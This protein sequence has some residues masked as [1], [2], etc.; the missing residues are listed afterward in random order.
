MHLL[1]MNRRQK[2]QF[3]LSIDMFFKN[4]GYQ[5]CTD[6]YTQKTVTFIQM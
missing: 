2:A 5:Y 6:R 3:S 4:F 1:L